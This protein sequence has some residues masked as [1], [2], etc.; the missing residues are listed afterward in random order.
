MDVL[1]TSLPVSRSC[2]AGSKISASSFPT[3]WA[4]AGDTNSGNTIVTLPSSNMT[5]LIITKPGFAVE[6]DMGGKG[7]GWLRAPLRFSGTSILLR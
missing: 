6:L 1:N 4:F 3:D 5:A 7:I 2:Q